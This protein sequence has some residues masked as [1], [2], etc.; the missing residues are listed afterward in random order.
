MTE[1][2]YETIQSVAWNWYKKNMMEWAIKTLK[3]IQNA[4]KWVRESFR[5]VVFCQNVDNKEFAIKYSEEIERVLRISQCRHFELNYSK[6]LQEYC[7]AKLDGN[8]EAMVGELCDLVLVAFNSGITKSAGIIVIDTERV[9]NRIDSLGYEPYSCLCEKLKELETRTGKWNEEEGK[10][11]KNLGAYTRE[12]AE[13]IAQE[14]DKQNER[15][16][17][18]ECERFWVWELPLSNNS[19]KIDKWYKADFS[20]CKVA[21][22]V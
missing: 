12:E 6:E 15:V 16:F 17:V 3:N 8:I 22:N 14:Y 4:P 18:E 19:L 2:Q 20:K 9:I 13:K 7:E 1:Q 5:N 10:W 11:C 21:N